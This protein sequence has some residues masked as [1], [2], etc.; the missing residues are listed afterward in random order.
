MHNGI[1]HSALNKSGI[2]VVK[3]MRDA[4]DTS[5]PPGWGLGAGA[6]KSILSC[7]RVLNKQ[8]LFFLLALMALLSQKVPITAKDCMIDVFIA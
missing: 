2:R 7:C 8:E 3:T 1:E 4:Q 5:F 6:K